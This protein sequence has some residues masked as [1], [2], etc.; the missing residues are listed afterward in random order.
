MEPKFVRKAFIGT[1]V[2]KAEDGS[3]RI[4]FKASDSTPDR[5]GERIFVQGMDIAAYEKNPIMQWAHDAKQPAI[6]TGKVWKEGTGDATALYF[7][8]VFA[9]TPRAQE[10]KALVEQGVVKAVSVGVQIFKVAN[11][12]NAT[13]GIDMTETS[14]F[15]VS[16]CNVPMNEG[17][18]RVQA[19][20]E[21]DLAAQ[22]AELRAE[23]KALRE[24]SAPPSEVVIEVTKAL[25]IP[26]TSD[27]SSFESVLA[28]WVNT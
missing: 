27:S 7:E 14:L 15:E 18:L 5:M 26:E 3:K 4:V 12:T 20:G 10:V 2:R 16:L 24:K 23:V 21:E 17:T 19:V 6:G 8:P 11:K 1:E 28:E 13:G 25:P 9:D 22:I